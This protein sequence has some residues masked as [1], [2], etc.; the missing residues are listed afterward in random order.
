MNFLNNLNA[1]NFQMEK[2]VFERKI[3]E[4]KKNF[5]EIFKEH[6]EKDYNVLINVPV[7]LRDKPNAINLQIYGDG[8]V[9]PKNYV[10]DLSESQS[11]IKEQLSVYKD[12]MNDFF[13][14]KEEKKVENEKKEE[15][16]IH[17]PVTHG[18]SWNKSFKDFFKEASEVA[19]NIGYDTSQIKWNNREKVTITNGN[20]KFQTPY[21][22]GILSDDIRLLKTI[23]ENSSVPN[24]SFKNEHGE[25]KI[26]NGLLCINEFQSDYKFD[27]KSVN[28]VLWDAIDKIQEIKQISDEFKYSRSDFFDMETGSLEVSLEK[29]ENSKNP[30]LN[31]K[32]DYPGHEIEIKDS[33]IVSGKVSPRVM[34]F[35][36]SLEAQHQIEGIRELINEAKYGKMTEYIKEGNVKITGT[37]PDY[38]MEIV[39]F[40]EENLEK[41]AEALSDI[42]DQNVK[43]SLNEKEL[44]EKIDKISKYS[45]N[46]K[47]IGF[48]SSNGFKFHLFKKEFL[49]VIPPEE[50]NVL[51]RYKFSDYV[52]K[53]MENVR[54][55]GVLSKSSDE[56]TLWKDLR[57]DQYNLI[58]KE[59]SNLETD[60][61]AM[62]KISAYEGKEQK[63][64]INNLSF[65]IDEPKRQFRFSSIK[66]F[67][68][69]I[70]NKVK[71]I[72][73]KWFFTVVEDQKEN[74]KENTQEKKNQN[75][76]K[77]ER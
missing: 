42:K 35:L 8:E 3:A 4:L 33:K 68:E 15:E 28:G 55:L 73:H 14:S 20:I 64:T 50:M 7:G 44:A 12:E 74:K 61:Q 9:S 45:D 47:N 21:G 66:E 5:Q 13:G 1:D 46:I 25:Y 11:S 22:I 62:K 30:L 24:I 31:F 18:V 56:S 37:F 23:K 6:I 51:D 72:A 70:I 60:L 49:T 77:R 26:E 36:L 38:E 17:F 40:P 63:M 41:F 27:E 57:E 76:T 48:L 32:Y 29:K 71:E 75:E 54:N 53:N 34:E 58:V 67:S 16:F 39:K 52:T 43:T 2:E 69:K 19:K 59:T 10:I 65:G